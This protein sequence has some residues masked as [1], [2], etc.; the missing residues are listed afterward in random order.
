MKNKI[1]NCHSRSIK[2]LVFL[3]KTKLEG[4]SLK[5]QSNSESSI[6][7]SNGSTND[8]VSL[9]SKF[10]QMLKKNDIDEIPIKSRH[11]KSTRSHKKKQKSRKIVGS[12]NE[13]T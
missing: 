9:M 4:K 12:N 2:T 8:D 11:L 3:S 1:E 10:K 7:S 5:A 13:M 6:E